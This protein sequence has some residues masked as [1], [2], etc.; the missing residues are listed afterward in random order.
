MSEIFPGKLKLFK[1]ID[2]YVTSFSFSS[3]SLFADF[4][5][6]IYKFQQ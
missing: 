6:I 5:F 4:T 3:F 1:D 2:A